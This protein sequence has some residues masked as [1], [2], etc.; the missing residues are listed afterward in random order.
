MSPLADLT[1]TVLM[2]AYDYR[3]Q[4]GKEFDVTIQ[5]CGIIIIIVLIINLLKDNRTK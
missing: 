5:E 3:F 1:L 4:I 2:T